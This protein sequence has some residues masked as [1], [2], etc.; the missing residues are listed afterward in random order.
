MISAF[1]LLLSSVGRVREGKS[2]VP[3]VVMLGFCGVVGFGS[4]GLDWW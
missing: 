4:S 1:L 3:S 2:V